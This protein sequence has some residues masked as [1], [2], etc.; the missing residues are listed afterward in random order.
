MKCISDEVCK[1]DLKLADD[2][3]GYTCVSTCSTEKF[4]EDKDTAELRCVEDC[5]HWWYRAEDGLCKEQKWRKN[6]AIAVPIVVVVAIIA[7]VVAFVAGKKCKG[8]R[9]PGKTEKMTG[10]EDMTVDDA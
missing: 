4:E 5:S 10:R 8:G 6:T 2:G 3:F 7:V 9:K 1:G